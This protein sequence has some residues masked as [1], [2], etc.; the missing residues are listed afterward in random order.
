MG[1]HAEPSRQESFKMR[2]ILLLTVFTTLGFCQ[3]QSPP[4]TPLTEPP[5]GQ[6]CAGR[7]SNG[8]RCCTPES[9]CGYGEGDCDGP[10]DGGANDGHRGCQGDLVCGSN[11]CNVRQQ[12]YGWGP[13]SNWT[14]CRRVHQQISGRCRK[15]R[16]RN[17][18]GPQWGSLHH[19]ED[20]QEQYCRESDCDADVF[21]EDERFFF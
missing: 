10:L 12:Q 16:T 7:N 21:A 13:W 14:A 6:R 3:R 5:Q 11:N 1:S 18:V 9:P 2:I 8:R 4:S 20:L 17:C 15:T 19:S